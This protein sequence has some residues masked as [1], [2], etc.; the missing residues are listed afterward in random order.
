MTKN[1]CPHCGKIFKRAGNLK[2]HISKQHASEF[3]CRQCKAEF[4]SR[5]RPP[6]A[7]PRRPLAAVPGRAVHLFKTPNQH[8]LKRHMK[9]MHGQN[10]YLCSISWLRA[11]RHMIEAHSDRLPNSPANVGL[12]QSGGLRRRRKRRTPRGPD[13]N[14]ANSSRK[15]VC[16]KCKKR[17]ATQILLRRH[18]NAVHL[19]VYKTFKREHKYKCTECPKAFKTPGTLDDHLAGH[20]GETQYECERCQKSFIARAQFAVHLRKY[21]AMSI[22]DVTKAAATVISAGA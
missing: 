3:V 8:M 10:S 17:F 2:D 5:E 1:K 18:N 12:R 21:H 15:L 13:E 9:Q 11:H 22:K 7:H 16:T 14:D 20:R 19:K 6:R 4:E